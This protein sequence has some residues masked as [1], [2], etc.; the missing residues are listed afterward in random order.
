MKSFASKIH[1][2]FSVQLLTLYHE[3][4]EKRG[5]VWWGGAPETR[6]L[7]VEKNKTSLKQT[8]STINSSFFF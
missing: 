6:E 5:G 3:D 8:I 2:L 7:R 4:L 1:T